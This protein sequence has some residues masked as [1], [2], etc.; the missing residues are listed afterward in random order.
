MV[1]HIVLWNFAEGLT[2]EENKKNA[3]KIKTELES[4][5]NIIEG[6]I[7][8]RVHTQLLPSGD[9]DVILDSLFQDQASLDAY[10]VHPEHVKIGQEVKRCFTNRRC[11]DFVI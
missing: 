11:A 7:E 6:V 4:L 5:K 8:L 3:E 10:A 2:Q 9:C 1:R